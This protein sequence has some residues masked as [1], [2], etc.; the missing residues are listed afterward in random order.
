M[1]KLIGAFLILIS[2]SLA[3]F[4]KA[5]SLSARPKQI[6]ALRSFLSILETEIGYGLR[7]LVQ[8]CSSVAEGTQEPIASI[9]HASAYNLSNLDGASTYECFSKAIQEKWETTELKEQEKKILLDLS[10][11]LGSSSREDQLN[12]LK[13]AVANL[14]TM[15]VEAA[16]E[17]LRFTKM[18]RTLGV[19]LGLLL[20]ILM[21]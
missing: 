7:P 3:G 13:L 21:Y 11:V 8:A 1:L 6:R 18:Y 14:E 5:R 20:V 15:E 2:T 9:F 17:E 4:L 10:R 19:L 12:H 16:G